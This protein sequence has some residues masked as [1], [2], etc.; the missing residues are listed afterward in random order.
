ML[1]QFATEVDLGVPWIPGVLPCS[2]LTRASS[3]ISPKGSGA[4]RSLAPNHVLEI[5]H[6]DTVLVVAEQLG[7]HQ[8][9]EEFHHEP[10]RY[11]ALD[12]QDL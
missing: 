8:Y 1:L 6:R 4:G 12:Q 10:A 9:L 5:G 2:F 3:F 7:R 11:H